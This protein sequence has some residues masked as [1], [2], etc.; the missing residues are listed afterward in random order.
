M[1]DTK[2]EYYFHSVS[3]LQNYYL[4]NSILRAL[5]TSYRLPWQHVR[6]TKRSS[7]FQLLKI[8]RKTKPVTYRFYFLVGNLPKFFKFNYFNVMITHNEVM[9]T[10]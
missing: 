9:N 10:Q 5:M 2:E 3:K 7:I 1:K 8:I 4:F 6:S